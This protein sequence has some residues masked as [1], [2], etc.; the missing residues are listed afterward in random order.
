MRFWGADDKISPKWA[1]TFFYP[2]FTVGRGI[3]PHPA[4]FIALVGYT[5]DR[6]FHPAP[7]A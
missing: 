7:K 2:D 6:E 3:S 4:L 5:T 1:D